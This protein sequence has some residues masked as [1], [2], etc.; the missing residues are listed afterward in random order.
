MRASRGSST[1]FTCRPLMRWFT[2][3]GLVALIAQ[4]V[5][6]WTLPYIGGAW[7]SAVVVI[8]WSL[9][10]RRQ[11]SHA[12]DGCRAEPQPPDDDPAGWAKG[13]LLEHVRHRRSGVAAHSAGE[14]AGGGGRAPTRWV[15]LVAHLWMYWGPFLFLSSWLYVGLWFIVSKR[16]IAG[17]ISGMLV[18]VIAVVLLPTKLIVTQDA[19]LLA[20]T[21]FVSQRGSLFAAY[22]FWLP[23]VHVKWPT[24]Q[25]TSARFRLGSEVDLILGTAVAVVGRSSGVRARVALDGGGQVFDVRLAVAD[26]DLQR[27]QRSDRGIGRGAQPRDLAAHA[28]VAR[29]LVRAGRAPLLAT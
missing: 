9:F 1:Y 3:V 19:A 17:V 20:P 5:V 16:S 18:L 4:T 29:G 21:L 14:R 11:H 8:A 7:G 23:R 22:F 27:R 28:L 6:I 2:V 12:D 13:A 24:L 26:D 15:H 25:R 10:F